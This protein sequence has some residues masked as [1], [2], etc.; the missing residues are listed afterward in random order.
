MNYKRQHLIIDCFVFPGNSGGPVIQVSD[1][2]DDAK[3]TLIGLV[4]RYIPYRQVQVIPIENITNTNYIN[5]GYALIVS[6]DHVIESIV[7][8]SK[9]LPD[10]YGEKEPE[11][12]DSLF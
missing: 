9:R 8:F 5:S 3:D 7:E 10:P 4:S 12:W 2:D 6:M 11:D 1:S